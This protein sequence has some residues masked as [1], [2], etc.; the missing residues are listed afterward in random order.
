MLMGKSP[1]GIEASLI[2]L[3]V[4]ALKLGNLVKQFHVT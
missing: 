1:L 4:K 2:Y 3:A